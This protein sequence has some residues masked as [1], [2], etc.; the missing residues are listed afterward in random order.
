MNA[1]SSNDKSTPPQVL[2]GR[3]GMIKQ[4]EDLKS[5]SDTRSALIRWLGFKVYK[6]SESDLFKIDYKKALKA[7]LSSHAR[8]VKLIGVLVRDTEP[9]VKD[10]RARYK[11]LA[12]NLDKMMNLE[13]AA[14]Y[15][16][17]NIA[18][19]PELMEIVK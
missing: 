19:L 14:F 7:Y 13:L 17:V 16:S 10:L 12:T 1:K 2:Y 3:S 18:E 11:A 6:L 8:R 9:T 15:I 5:S 4:L